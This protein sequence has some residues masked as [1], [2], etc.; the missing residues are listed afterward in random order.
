MESVFAPY[1][2]AEEKCPVY[3][4][5]FYIYILLKLKKKIIHGYI[6]N[7]LAGNVIFNLLLLDD[8]MTRQQA[9]V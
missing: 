4:S 5:I 9:C 8:D 3:S 2:I 1:H 7:I 6:K